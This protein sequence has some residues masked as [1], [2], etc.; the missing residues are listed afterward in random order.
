MKESAPYLRYPQQK[1]DYSLA[2]LAANRQPRMLTGVIRP[3]TPFG[4]GD[5]EHL[6]KVIVQV[7][8]GKARFQVG[9]GKNLFDYV[10]VRNLVHGHML[11]AEALLRASSIPQVSRFERVDGEAF[12]ITNDEHWFFW[13]FT[14]AVA[15]KLG[16]PVQREEIVVVP[17]AVGLLMAFLAEWIVWILSLGKKQSNMT[18]EAIRY[19]TITKTVN[20]DKAKRFLGYRPIF[21]MQEGLDKSVA[22]F[23]E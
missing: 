10:Y 8:S 12:H 6:A 5:Y 9:N 19:S 7:E 15:A 22:W 16:R 14:R 2:R 23:V 4:E 21:T 3:C 1:R 13:D 17:K 20:I 18:L 11:L